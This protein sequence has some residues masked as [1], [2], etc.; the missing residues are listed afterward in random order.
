[1]LLTSTWLPGQVISLFFL[2]LL[3]N[4]IGFSHLSAEEQKLNSSEE[5]GSVDIL[6]QITAKGR[7]YGFFARSG[8][9]FISCGNGG[10]AASSDSSSRG[11]SEPS[12]P[13]PPPKVA[14]IDGR[15]SN[16]DKKEGDDRRAPKRSLWKKSR[17]YYGGVTVFQMLVAHLEYGYFHQQGNTVHTLLAEFWQSQAMHFENNGQSPLHMFAMLLGGAPPQ[18]SYSN[19]VAVID[20]LA[21]EYLLKNSHGTL[22]TSIAWF[23][24]SHYQDYL[25][26][27]FIRLFRS[28]FG[29]SPLSSDTE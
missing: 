9:T 25:I 11:S 1:M 4:F 20:Q 17:P 7:M 21:N 13:A 12:V 10:E 8:G 22:V 6:L 14:H 27:D 16:F 29:L 5:S 24:D 18:L 26:F 2:A 15:Y 19:V 28:C 3:L 23:I